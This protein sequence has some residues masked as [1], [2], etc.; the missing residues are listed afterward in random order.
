[1][2]Q[3]LAAYKDTPVGVGKEYWKLAVGVS[4]T[5]TIV[6]QYIKEI[7]S[8]TFSN[9]SSTSTIPYAVYVPGGTSAVVHAGNGDSIIAIVEGIVA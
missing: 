6:P 5:E 4:T 7:L 1:M 8:V 2:S 3:A 9:L